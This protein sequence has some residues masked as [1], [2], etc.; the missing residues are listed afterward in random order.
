MH[1]FAQIAVIFSICVVAEGIAAILPFTFPSS[2]LG[3]L[4]LLALLLTKVLKPKQLEETSGFFLNN[5]TFFF[6]P[7]CVGI[8]KYTDVL[9]SNF[10]AIVLI[11]ILTTPLVFFVTGHVVQ[12]TMKKTKEKGETE[13]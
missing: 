12:L 7:T 10:W 6:V 8:L 11:S 13:K 1:I 9:F 4:I 2:V 3:M 5:M